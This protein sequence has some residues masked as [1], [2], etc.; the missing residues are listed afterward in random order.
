[1]DDQD[2]M[3]RRRPSRSLPAPHPDAD[4]SNLRDGGFTLIEVMVATVVFTILATAFAAALSG[5]LTSFRVSRTRTLAEETATATLEDAR[6]LA[7][8]DLGIVGGNPPGV[9]N[10]TQT[11][12]VGGYQLSVATKVSYVNDPLPGGFE[13][14][15][16]Y[17]KVTITV[18]SG[19]AAVP[20]AKLETLVAPPS[21]P[22]LTKGLIKVQVV[23]YALNQPIVGATVSLGTGP[24]APRSDET[25]SAGKVTFAALDPTPASGATSTYTV[26]PTIAGYQVLPEDQP[27][28]PAAKSA[29]RPARRSPR[30]CG[31]SSP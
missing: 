20:M 12:T 21:Q 27:P 8:D 5:S 23:D 25:D 24:S 14:G 11:V 26:T 9:L 31:C 10:A 13:T 22:S 4:A 18:T 15:A 6:R 7:Y 19:V 29:L 17:K 16:N 1:M 28:S 2:G 3:V 30:P